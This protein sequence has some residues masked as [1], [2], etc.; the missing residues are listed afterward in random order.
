VQV[1]FAADFRDVGADLWRRCFP[2]PLEGQFWYRALE[3]SGLEEQFAFRYGVLRRGGE[4]V[5]IVPCFVHDVSIALVAPRPVAL[6]LRVLSRVF[7]R[8]GR[9]RTFFVGSPCSDE[10]SVGLLPGVNLAEVAPEL[11]RAL[12]AEARRLGAPMIV[13]KDFPEAASAALDAPARAAGFFGVVSY[14]GTV[15]ALPSPDRG[16]YL[17][18]LSSMQRH[19]FLKKLRRSRERLALE[20]SV[21]E[22]PS[23]RELEE[24]H[25][26]FRQT[27]EKGA[28]KFE[29]LGPPFFRAV[30]GEEP[31]RFILQRDP[32]TGALLTFMLVFCLG[33]RVINKFI[34]ID[35][36]R[37]GATYLYFRLFDAALD[38]AYARGARE[39][40]SGQT[41][42]RAK[43]DLG[44][45]LVPLHNLVRHQNR[46]VHAVYRMIGAR[47]TWKT[48]DSDLATFL[49]AH[50]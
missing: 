39:L 15:L 33:D 26:L 34:G 28:T 30:A 31:A 19:N 25:G 29:R 43:L 2:P 24:I 12:R 23:D 36:R 18:G 6:L 50:P 7:P 27:Y 13:F 14:P 4:T 46:L 47:V 32:A 42:Y 17:R 22:R 11:I 48:L 38:F 20:T 16:A 9:Q 10:G 44:H 41:G 5:G 21:V 45:R 8:A 40:Q 37:A 49:L 3:H 1:E 35:Y